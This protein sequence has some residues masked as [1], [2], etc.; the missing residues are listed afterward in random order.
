MTLPISALLTSLPL[1][2]EDGLIE[3][4]NLG[5]SH[6]DLVALDERPAPHLDALAES[7]LIVSCVALGRELPPEHALDAESRTLR[8]ETVTFIRRQIND[9]AYLGA[10]HAYLVPGSND[11]E[12]GRAYFSEGCKILSEIAADRMIQ[13]CVEHMPGSWLHSAAGTLLWLEREKLHETKLL[14]DVGHC[15]ISEE[16]PAAIVH[17]AGERLGYVHMDDNDGEND[18]HWALLKGRLTQSTLERTV[19]ALI[20]QQYNHCLSLELKPE[21]TNRKDLVEGKRL[22]ERICYGSSLESS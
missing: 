20:D 12:S 17:E 7:G 15:L 1:S 3:L 8:S 22:L 16:V 6:V 4:A 14:L 21:H 18:L 11:S 9:A 5:F 19:E 2:V 10:T 13:L